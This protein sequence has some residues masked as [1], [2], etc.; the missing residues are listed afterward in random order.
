MSELSSQQL[1]TSDG[2]LP[3]PRSLA[4]AAIARLAGLSAE[5]R[6][7]ASALAVVN[8]R[9]PLGVVARIAGLKHPTAA[10]ESLLGTGFVRWMPGETGTPVEYVHPL[11][12]VAVYEDLSPVRRQE[13]HRMAAGVLEPGAAL[14]HRVAA[15][16][17]AD[18]GLAGELA[19]AAGRELGQGAVDLAVRYLLWAS[20]L[21]S[22][23]DLAEFRFLQ[24]ARLLVANGQAARAAALR[25]RIG[26]CRDGPVRSLVLGMLAWREGDASAEQWLSRVLAS[27]GDRHG[28]REVL[29]AALAELGGLYTTQGRAREAVEVATRALALVPADRQVEQ[30]AWQALV[31]GE[32]MRRGAPAGLDRLSERLPQSA[33]TIRAA[34][35]DLLVTRGSL[36]F[37][38]GRTS[39]AAA[40]MRV[41]VRLA[42]QGSVAVQLP[43]AHLH[44]SEL[45]VNLG[46]WDEA[47][48][49]A[50]LALSLV[51]DEQLVWMQAQAHAVL[52][53]LL[54]CGGAWDAA[55]DHVTAAGEAAAALG[56][57][58]AV[59]KTRI[60]EAALARARHQ[61]EQVVAALQPLA[62][63]GDVAAIPMFT[64]LGWWP[65]LIMAIID[66]G[67]TD[68]A[69]TQINDLEQA[70]SD[71]R[72]DLRARIA[73]LRARVA[74]AKGRP[75]EAYA[76]FEAAIALL[77]P[78]DPVLDRALLHHAFGR[79]QRAR[80]DRRAAV[81]Q[82]R[83]AYEL[84]DQLGAEPFRVPVQADLAVCGVRAATQVARSPLALTSRERDV[85]VLVAKGMTN[86]EV[87]AELYVSDKAVEYHLR[88]VFGK[89]GV[90]S[91]RALRDHRFD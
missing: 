82:L 61:P 12:R 62:G 59:F 69:Q 87:A 60:A 63:N 49:H 55:A 17:T 28:D 18:D 65:P 78:D 84:L 39:A 15:A 50:R 46:D 81:G 19:E 48:V 37:Y 31:F 26:A 42:R 80:G 23:R 13:L 30:A 38:A 85:A 21:S 68:A 76:H 56:N 10:L 52:G 67:D 44:L 20:P 91:R 16:D 9:V 6:V 29:A 47:Q 34:D 51:S 5:T 35:C 86:R 40:D 8:D 88:N 25:S 1:A 2:E 72:L 11:Y 79:L 70:A 22:R 4:S 7:L 43:R 3:A 66:C 54:A 45:L 77:G 83:L 90:R 32:G 53:G 57:F 24:A 73:G 64:S 71:R 14:A 36:G 75:E 74:Q 27:A 33:E 41:V 89:L 58:E